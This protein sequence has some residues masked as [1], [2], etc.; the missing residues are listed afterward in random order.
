MATYAVPQEMSERM[1][2]AVECRLLIPK[3]AVPLARQQL[4]AAWGGSPY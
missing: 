4:R 1:L 3:K 2:R